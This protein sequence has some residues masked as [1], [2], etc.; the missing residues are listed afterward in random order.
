MKNDSSVLH[1]GTI[2]AMLNEALR[3][4][5]VPVSRIFYDGESDVFLTY[6]RITVIKVNFADDTDEG[7][8]IAFGVDLF[9]HHSTVSATN[10]FELLQKIEIAVEEKGFY[11]FEIE[12][13]TFEPETGYYHIPMTIKYYMEE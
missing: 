7:K 12:S 5:K 8:E 2:D 4:T 1:I 13:E 11:G 9:V 6:Q 10:Y 3:Q